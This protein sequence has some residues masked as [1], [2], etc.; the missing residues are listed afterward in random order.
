[1]DENI[2]KLNEKMKELLALAKKKQNVLDQSE[3][4]AAL[5]DVEFDADKIDLI[6]KYLENN[7]ID[8][9]YPVVEE[10]IDLDDADL[11][12]ADFDIENLDLSI[13]EGVSFTC[14]KGMAL[15]SFI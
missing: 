9:I 3:I 2:V 13:P 8:I 14:K 4:V 5:S 10:D 6:Y 15:T 1:M 12:E 7:G 11:S